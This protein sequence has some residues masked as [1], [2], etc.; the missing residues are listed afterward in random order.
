MV[1]DRFKTPAWVDT[2][3][4][5]I[6]NLKKGTLFTAAIHIFCGIVGAGVLALPRSLGWLGWVAGPILII[7]FYLISLLSSWL[8]ADCY[9]VEGVENGRYHDIVK[10][11]MGI[12]YAYGVSVFQ[13]LNIVLIDIAY[14]ITAAKAMVTLANTACGWQGI[15]SGDCFNTSWI[16]TVIFG[17][18]QIVSSLV[19]NLESAWW[20]SFIGVITSLFYSSVALA[21][22]LK[23]ASNR[24]GTVGGIPANHVNKAFE[25]LNA[26]GAIGF[27]YSFSSILV[28]IQDTLRQPPKAAK[29]MSKATNVSVTASFA[30]Y[31]VVAIGGYA[32]L[33]NDVPSYILGGLQGPEWVIFVAN[34]CVLLHMWSAYQI[35]AHPMFDTLESHVKAFK[36]RQAKAKGDAELPAKVEELKRMSLAARQGSAA[37]TKTMD[38]TAPAAPPAANPLRRLSR[39]SAMAGEKLQRLSQNAAMYRVSTGFA[40]TSVPSNDDHFVLPW[41]QRL[42]TRGIYVVLTTLIAAIMPFFGAMA[43]LVGALAFFPLTVFFPFRCWRTVYKPT[44]WFNY[45]LYVIEFGMALVC[46][47]ATIASFRNIIV[48][49]STFKIFEGAGTL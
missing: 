29:T 43:G 34:L 36:L 11:I 13:T 1:C 45:M 3:P 40:D 24:L 47:A 39:V 22:G 44:G 12:K 27:A 41:W 4:E 8:L 23:S 20:V 46:V 14:T 33:G 9:E 26:L 6:P 35:Y 10:H 37:G 7:V 49:W 5:G 19:P 25:I 38:D 48:S 17:G 42:I 28:E 16:M 30:F 2:H 32:S 21:L 18:V 15:D 31:F